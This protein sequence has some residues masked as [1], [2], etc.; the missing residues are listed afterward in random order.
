MKV[1]ENPAEIA[2]IKVAPYRSL[3][4]RYFETNDVVS[5]RC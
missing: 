1:T 3:C 4:H 5:E 2:G